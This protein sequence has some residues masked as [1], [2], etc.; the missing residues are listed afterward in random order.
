[1]FRKES[2]DVLIVFFCLFWQRLDKL[3]IPDIE[4]KDRE[5]DGLR[6]DPKK[7]ETNEKSQLITG[8]V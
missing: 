5:I 2:F 4:E 3:F 6:S 1:M 7:T 8:S